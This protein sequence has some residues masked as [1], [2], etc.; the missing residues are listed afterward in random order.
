MENIM[1]IIQGR[2]SCHCERRSLLQGETRDKIDH[3]FPMIKQT[4]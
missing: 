1:F 3:K 2:I 4:T